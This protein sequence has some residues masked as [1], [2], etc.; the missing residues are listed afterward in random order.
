MSVGDGVSVALGDCV[1]EL[2]PVP[3]AVVVGVGVVV[4]LG[5][6]VSD[7]D[8]VSV[9]VCVADALVDGVPDGE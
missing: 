7:P 5:V 6:I 1:C 9:W 2:D 4:A 8:C 3:E